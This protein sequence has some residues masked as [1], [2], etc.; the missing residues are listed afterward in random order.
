MFKTC[1]FFVQ[2]LNKNATLHY[3]DFH[4]VHDRA[5]KCAWPCAQYSWPYDLYTQN[6]TFENIMHFSK[7]RT[8]NGV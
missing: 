1:Q 6:Y 7:I 4:N 2:H 3:A 8:I 5:P